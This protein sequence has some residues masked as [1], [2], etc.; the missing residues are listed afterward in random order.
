MGADS[1]T[2]AAPEFSQDGCINFIGV[3]VMLLFYFIEFEKG[4]KITMLICCAC[5]SQN[6]H[7]LFLVFL[8]VDDPQDGCNAPVAKN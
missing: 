4:P 3:G 1:P 8:I 5:T 6:F 7:D 2:G